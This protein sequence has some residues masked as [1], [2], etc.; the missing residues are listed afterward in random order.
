MIDVAGECV[1][2]GENRNVLSKLVSVYNLIYYLINP[3]EYKN[4]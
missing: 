1:I 2:N 3:F 4:I